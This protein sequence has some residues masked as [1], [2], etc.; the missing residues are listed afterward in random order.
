LVVLRRTGF[1]KIIGG[2]TE[3]ESTRVGSSLK[4]IGSEFI[5]S[6][7]YIGFPSGVYFYQLKAGSYIETKKMVLMK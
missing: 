4:I 6:E 1:D 3:L 2:T 5:N 7:I